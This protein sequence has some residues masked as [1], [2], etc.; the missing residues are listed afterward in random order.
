MVVQK[1]GE[2]GQQ[3]KLI[4]GTSIQTIPSPTKTITLQQAQEMGLL[5]PKMLPQTTTTSTQKHTVLINK[6]PQKTIKI[7][8]QTTQM[9]TGK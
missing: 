9:I 7:M 8:P 3:M 6:N 1:A 5:S 2:P 4:Q